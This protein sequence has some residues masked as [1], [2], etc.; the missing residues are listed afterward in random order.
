MGADRNHGRKFSGADLP[1][2][3]IGHDRIAVALHGA[4]NFARQIG[5]CR[6]AIEQNATG[7]AQ[8]VVSPGKY[9]AA[10][11]ETDDRIEPCPAEK[12]PGS[13]GDNGEAARECIG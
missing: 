1:D 6:R 3:Q 2:V 10:T 9:D 5:I 4:A 8:E 7:I 12:F 11:D 13:Q